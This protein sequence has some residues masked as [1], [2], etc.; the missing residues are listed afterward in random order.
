MRNI[1]LVIEYDGTNFNGWQTQPQHRTIQ[2][3]I[4]Q[5]LQKIFNKKT[6]L[7]GS[8][9][10][11]SGVHALGQVANFKI[12][13]TMS[14]EKMQKA[15]NAVLPVDIV[16]LDI[17]EVPLTFHAQYDAKR[18]IY[19]YT[20]LNR[21]TRCAQQRNFC[22]F[23]PYELN[24]H[25]MRDEAKSLLGTHDFK[26]FQS[27]DTSKP[28]RSKNTIRTVSLFNI[29]KR[30]DY[31]YIDI[32]ANGFLY[33]MVRTIV[34]TMLEIGSGKLS[35]GSMQEILS[36]KNRIHAGYTVKAKG[37]TLMAVYYTPFKKV[38]N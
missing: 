32:E 6:R 14:C 4:E 11:D 29:K 1:K 33:K 5:A 26:S 37:L 2:N 3:E 20:I 7:I 16:I 8:G 17:E 21:S 27:I 12:Q 24:L 36:Q 34:G 35:K 30:G 22:L 18:K 23:Y 31:I 13:S 15:L 25:L 28:H 9:R 38:E 10:T 19:R